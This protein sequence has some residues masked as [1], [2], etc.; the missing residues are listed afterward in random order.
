MNHGIDI[1]VLALGLWNERAP[2]R[3]QGRAANGS[4]VPQWNGTLFDCS[5][6]SQLRSSLDRSGLNATKIAA[7]DG[8]PGIWFFEM[9]KNIVG[10]QFQAIID[11][12]AP[13][14]IVATHGPQSL[15]GSQEAHAESEGWQHWESEMEYPYTGAARMAQALVR[16]YIES[17]VTAQIVWPAAR[18]ATEIL[19]TVRFK[20]SNELVRLSYCVV[21]Q[22]S[23]QLC[24]MVGE[25]CSWR[26]TLHGVV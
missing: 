12:K 5:V 9:P 25:A 17:N 13:I 1:C 2:C 7:T 26:R 4:L 24:H 16:D 11:T 23:I 18:G 20:R 15:S 19:P 8:V 10:D 22:V 14:D 6:V 3:S 21:W